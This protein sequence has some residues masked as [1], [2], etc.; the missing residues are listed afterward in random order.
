MAAKTAWKV[1]GSLITAAEIRAE[2]AALRQE[3]ESQGSE[4]SMEDRLALP[5]MARERLVER[6]VLRTSAQ[7]MGFAASDEEVQDALVRLA[8]RNDGVSGC[9][10]GMASEENVAEIRQRVAIDKLMQSVLGKVRRPQ[11][12]QIQEFYRKNLAHFWT[13]ALAHVW[14]LVKS[15]DGAEAAVERM[16]QR[17]AD[18]AEFAQV[19]KEESECPEHG[20]DLGYFVHGT[21]VDEFEEV[22]FQ[23]PIGELTPVFQTRFGF[24]TAMVKDR[25]PA[26][27]RALEEVE[28]EIETILLRQAQ[29]AACGELMA[30]LRKS[31]KIEQ[32]SE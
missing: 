6:A 27:V 16:R 1:N 29:D 11:G 5:E 31:A 30:K 9:R 2:A 8:P 13:P 4:L 10:A 22:V 24:H 12:W 14:H 7:R 19:A 26:G 21:M 32:V 18:G 15:G 20:G 23:A 28:P 25:K 3:A 17:V